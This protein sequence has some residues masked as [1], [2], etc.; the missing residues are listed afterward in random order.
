MAGMAICPDF[1]EARHE[2]HS[3]PGAY[4]QMAPIQRLTISSPNFSTGSAPKAKICVKITPTQ[5]FDLLRS[6]G[7]KRFT[8]AQILE[9]LFFDL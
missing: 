1:P 8:E 5:F 2:F 6:R 7:P 4:S 9:L 3:G